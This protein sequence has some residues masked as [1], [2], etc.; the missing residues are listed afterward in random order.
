[1]PRHGSQMPPTMPPTDATSPAP[2]AVK[3]AATSTTSPPPDTSQHPLNT[4]QPTPCHWPPTTPTT[5]PSNA[6]SLVPDGPNDATSPSRV[7]SRMVGIGDGS[8]CE[9]GRMCRGGRMCKGMTRRRA[10]HMPS[11]FFFRRQGSVHLAC[12]PVFVSSFPPQV[13][14]P[15]MLT[16]RRV[17]H[18]PSHF[19][20]FL[21]DGA[22]CTLHAALFSF[23][24]SAQRP[25][26][27][28]IYE[29]V[30]IPHAASLSFFFSLMGVE[31]TPILVRFPPQKGGFFFFSVAVS[32]TGVVYDPPTLLPSFPPIYWGFFFSAAVLSTRGRHTTHPPFPPL[33]FTP[34][35][36]GDFF[37]FCNC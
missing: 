15:L 30:C 23:F 13:P 20:S 2:N 25:S 19:L 32:S 36:W 7:T 10:S 4:P 18:T 17:S 12:C 6:M 34:Q 16:R 24:L 31:P 5:L 26:S 1:M 9:E 37:L 27:W 33:L 11:H 35:K 3:K 29:A 28:E 22:V 21:V 14:P 8:S